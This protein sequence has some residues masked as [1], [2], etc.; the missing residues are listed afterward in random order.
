M[1]CTQYSLVYADPVTGGGSAGVDGRG[2]RKVGGGLTAIIRG[3]RVN[4]QVNKIR[5]IAHSGKSNRMVKS[6]REGHFSL[7]SV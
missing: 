1:L 7:L 3:C 4:F 6:S 2:W 5:S